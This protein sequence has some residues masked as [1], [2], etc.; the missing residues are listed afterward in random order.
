MNLGAKRSFAKISES[1][2]SI[3]RMISWWA[4][5]RGDG[6]KLWKEPKLQTQDPV[7]MLISQAHLPTKRCSKLPSGRPQNPKSSKTSPEDTNSDQDICI[8]EIFVQIVTLDLNL[9]IPT[10]KSKNKHLYLR[11]SC[12]LLRNCCSPHNIFFRTEAG[13][14]SLGQ[15]EN[16]TGLEW[17]FGLPTAPRFPSLFKEK[18]LVAQ[19]WNLLGVFFFRHNNLNISY[20]GSSMYR[21]AYIVRKSTDQCRQ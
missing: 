20:L 14:R 19:D 2:G 21:F 17:E 10:N 5:T 18:M 9:S 11:H 15:G 4:K 3:Q 8:T 12:V 1:V 13:H 6:K 16:G 7:P